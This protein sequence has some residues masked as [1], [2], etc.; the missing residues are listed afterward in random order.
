MGMGMFSLK[1]AK[2]GVL[3]PPAGCLRFPN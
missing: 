3:F 1:K 2:S